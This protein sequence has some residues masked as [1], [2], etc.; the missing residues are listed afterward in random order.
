VRRLSRRFVRVVS[1][2]CAATAFGVLGSFVVVLHRDLAEARGTI[3]TLRQTTDA[4]RGE[5]SRLADRVGV[6]DR[7]LLDV[8]ALEADARARLM[9]EVESRAQGD[10]AAI[11]GEL[12]GLEERVRALRAAAEEH[13]RL[14]AEA[15]RSDDDEARYRELMSPTVRVN[16]RTEVG[17]GTVLWSRTTGDR[18][19]TYVLTAW[20]IVQDDVP[21]RTLDIDF[22]EDGKP[23][24]TDRGKV[25]AQDVTLD[26]ALIEVEG[27]QVH[28]WTARLADRA[29]LDTFG[30]FTPVRAIGCPLGYPP[31]PT[32]GELTS[33]DKVL[34]G[35]QYWMINAPVIFGNSGGGI[36]AARSHEMI[37]VLARISAYK[38]MIDVAVPHMGLVTP[39][40]RVYGWLD[41]TDYAF[42]Y[43]DRLAEARASTASP[44]P[45]A[46]S[47]AGSLP[48]SSG[49]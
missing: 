49:R 35:N 28:R 26:L 24:R 43:L 32:S 40:D 37:G 46:P 45:S 29:K 21:P 22:Y 41:R 2:A 30:V 11:K 38:N 16:A 13:A 33:R 27:G 39:M 44:A 34:D 23:L 12:A 19:R 47:P 42:V 14:L 17:S 6:V 20:H 4:Q 36:Y 3:D 9:S 7:G 18:A 15:Q 1:A 8:R 10:A 48:A 25:V 31:L 5:L